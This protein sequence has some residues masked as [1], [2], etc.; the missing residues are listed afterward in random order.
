MVTSKTHFEQVPLTFVKK[1]LAE[2]LKQKQAG[3][4]ALRTTSWKMPLGKNQGR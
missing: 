4:K 2:Q 3:R 1:I